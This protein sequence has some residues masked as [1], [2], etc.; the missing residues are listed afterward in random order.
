[1]GCN[2]ALDG[3]LIVPPKGSGALRPLKNIGAPRPPPTK[4]TPLQHQSSPIKQQ[5]QT[6][7]KI[8]SVSTKTMDSGDATNVEAKKQEYEESGSGRESAV[9]IDMRNGRKSDIKSRL[10]HNILAD[11]YPIDVMRDRRMHT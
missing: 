11:K 1:M 10:I 6:N 2:L 4:D 3:Q 9:P 8:K 7:N 5:A